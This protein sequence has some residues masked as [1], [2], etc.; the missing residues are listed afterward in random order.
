MCIF[1]PI[2]TFL[3]HISMDFCE[4]YTK[5]CLT[6]SEIQTKK[7]LKMAPIDG[8]IQ[9]WKGPKSYMLFV[10]ENIELWMSK[11]AK[12]TIFHEFCFNKIDMSKN[13]RFC[14]LSHLKICIQHLLDAY[15][16]PYESLFREIKR[17]FRPL[18][19]FAAFL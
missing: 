11:G 4:Y 7:M 17:T 13:Q 5:G 19:A 2:S 3:L 10:N 18:M 1:K 14:R 9:P 6:V 8:L 15:K 12:M 16:Q